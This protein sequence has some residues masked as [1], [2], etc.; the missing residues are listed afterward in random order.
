VTSAG[1]HARRGE[2]FDGNARSLTA[3]R[4]HSIRLT[5]VTRTVTSADREEAQLLMHA[6]EPL[7]TPD[8]A[9]SRAVRRYAYRNLRFF[10]ISLPFSPL[11]S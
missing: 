11:P 3:A 7:V 2:T 6:E 1:Q 8:A 5:S 4:F 9:T 10:G